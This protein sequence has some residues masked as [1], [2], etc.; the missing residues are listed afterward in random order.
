MLA[1]LRRL[2][3]AAL[4]HGAPLSLCAQGAP[5]AADASRMPPPGWVGS[6]KQYDAIKTSTDL[7]IPT[8][9]GK[10]MATDVYRPSRNGVPL[11]Q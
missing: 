5:P 7:M 6:P 4:L 10:R 9:D 8:R 2:V 11:A 1:P 3:I